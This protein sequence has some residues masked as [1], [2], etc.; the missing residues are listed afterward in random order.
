MSTCAACGESNFTPLQDKD[1]VTFCPPCWSALL[2]VPDHHGLLR[3]HEALRTGP[4]LRER[5][6]AVLV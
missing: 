6:A 1:D 3:D 5:L 2:D 4:P